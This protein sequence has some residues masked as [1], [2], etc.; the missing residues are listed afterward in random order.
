MSF[1]SMILTNQG[2]NALALAANGGSPV[3]LTEVA[4]GNVQWSP[5]AAATA[6]NNEV[7]RVNTINGGVSG[8]VIHMTVT[9]ASALAYDVREVGLFADDGVGGT[10]LFAIWSGPLL[11]SKASGSALFIAVDVAI[12]SVPFSPGDVTIGNT[13]FT[14]PAATETTAGLVRLATAAEVA[15]FSGAGVLQ[16]GDMA[17]FVNAVESEVASLQGKDTGH[18]SQIASL[19]TSVSSILATMES[20]LPRHVSTFDGVR[21]NNPASVTISASLPTLVEVGTNRRMCIAQLN[22]T[23][24]MPTN[25]LASFDASPRRYNRNTSSESAFGP[26]IEILQDNVGAGGGSTAERDFSVCWVMNDTTSVEELDVNCLLTNFTN[27]NWID[28]LTWSVIVI[29]TNI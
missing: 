13:D 20:R 6:L 29:P 18:D 17:A 25:S 12:I 19:Q 9:D 11:V 4:V 15:A 1:V 7:Q 14:L 3:L 28:D 2:A 16:A 10:F 5:T 26:T 27:V 23:I 24:A 8:N 22:G 21:K